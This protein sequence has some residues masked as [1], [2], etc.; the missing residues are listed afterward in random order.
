MFVPR[1]VDPLRVV[2]AAMNCFASPARKI[3]LNTEGVIAQEIKG[4][5]APKQR[6]LDRN[7]A[8]CR[9][10]IQVAQHSMFPQTVRCSRFRISRYLDAR[11]PRPRPID[12]FEVKGGSVTIL[13]G[14]EVRYTFSPL[15]RN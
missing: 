1:I 5:L 11:P 12:C 8:L 6:L 14:A 4:T 10:R 9:R 2:R 15:A 13:P 3:L 7:R